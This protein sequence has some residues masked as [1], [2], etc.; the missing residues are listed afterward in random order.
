MKGN[1]LFHCAAVTYLLKPNAKSQDYINALAFGLVSHRVLP[2]NIFVTTTD[3]AEGLLAMRWGG[4]NITGL[5]ERQWMPSMWM[6]FIFI[7]A[8]GTPGCLERGC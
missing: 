2:T 5:Y 8:R 1:I 3:A 4:F 6:I 7:M